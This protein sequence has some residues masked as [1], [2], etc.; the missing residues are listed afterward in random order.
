MNKKANYFL[1]YV[2]LFLMV[3]VITGCSEDEKASIPLA[4]RKPSFINSSTLACEITQRF[5]ETSIGPDG[6][7]SCIVIDSVCDP[8]LVAKKADNYFND[9]ANLYRKNAKTELFAKQGILIFATQ[10][11]SLIQ[12]RVGE[13]LDTY[14]TMKGITAG[15]KYMQMQKDGMDKG[16]DYVC[17]VMMKEVW[18]EIEHLHHLG[19]WEKLKLKISITWIGDAL[20][21]IGKPSDSLIGKI[22]TFA[23][24]VIG[25]VIGKTNSL[26]VTICVISLL[27]WLLNTLC[28]KLLDETPPADK[29]TMLIGHVKMSNLVFWVKL[30]INLIIIT[31]TLGTFT[32]FSNMRTEDILYL[33]AHNMPFVNIIDWGKMTSSTENF[34]F[35]IFI[36]GI[37]F[38][39]N[40]IM[41]PRRLLAYYVNSSGKKDIM[42]LNR[43]H[44]L[45]DQCVDITRKG[46]WEFRIFLGTLALVVIWE[47]LH[48]L[49]LCI[50]AV[51]AWLSQFLGDDDSSSD[52][53]DFSH[54]NGSSTAGSGIPSTGGGGAASSLL[55]KTQTGPHN[56]QLRSTTNTNL[57]GHGSGRTGHNY[58]YDNTEHLNYGDQDNIGKSL[59]GMGISQSIAAKLPK[60]FFK[61]PFKCTL[62]RVVKEGIILSCILII[63]TPLLFNGVLAMFFAIYLGVRFPIYLAMEFVYANYLDNHPNIYSRY[64]SYD[65]LSFKSYIPSVTSGDFWFLTL[66]YGMLVLLAY[67]VTYFSSAVITYTTDWIGGQ[68]QNAISEKIEVFMNPDSTYDY[69]DGNRVITFSHY[70]IACSFKRTQLGKVLQ[71]NVGYGYVDSLGNE[72]IPCQFPYATEFFNDRALVKKRSGD[73]LYGIDREGKT[74]FK[75]NYIYGECFSGGKA[76][77]TKNPNRDVGGFID[78]EGQIVIPAIYGLWKDE[79]QDSSFPL[80]FDGKA[81]V[82]R[83]GKN[84]YVDAEG[85]FTAA[86]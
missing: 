79:N 33:E 45:R 57:L 68:K 4:A 10:N 75:T 16:I 50:L 82:S 76:F 78:T 43:N 51:F 59:A 62:W 71:S 38:F 49:V 53:S 23:A 86:E 60:D 32:Y 31:P 20:Y 21:S 61:E 14:M 30:I 80:F 24:V 5:A 19:F 26:L 85:N 28:D 77:V 22:P 11:N 27:V 66:L 9:I 74:I 84:G 47:V 1:A 7:L 67:I 42:L 34:T 81:K 17:P 6:T 8:G 54:G 56:P 12:L 44:T 83:K 48:Y 72:V 37:L 65:K 40:Y 36:F 58:Q 55:H 25:R 73:P 29:E 39:L 13:E 69:K 18:N 35:Y 15:A 63:S 41:T 52:S 46:K 64:S 2:F 3:T 70:G